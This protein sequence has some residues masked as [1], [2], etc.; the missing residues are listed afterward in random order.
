[1]APPRARLTPTGLAG[2]ATSCRYSARPLS[3]PRASQLSA[4]PIR[5]GAVFNA[6][7]PEVER[8]RSYSPPASQVDVDHGFPNAGERVRIAVW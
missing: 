5:S 1:V 4:Q 6:R 7:V 3:R 8:R 2:A